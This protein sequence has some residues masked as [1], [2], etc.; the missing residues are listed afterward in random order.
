VEQ[1]ETHFNSASTT[2]QIPVI[3]IAVGLSAKPLK[4][5]DFVFQR[6]S[7]TTS[8]DSSGTLEANGVRIAVE[9]CVSKHPLH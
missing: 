3:G 2:P 4:N 9:G 5:R 1:P 7:K 8:M 6:S